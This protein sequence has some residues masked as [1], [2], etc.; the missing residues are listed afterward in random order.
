MPGKQKNGRISERPWSAREREI[1]TAGG[2]IIAAQLHLGVLGYEPG[3]ADG[4]LGKRTRAA[5]ELF[6]TNWPLPV[7]GDLE[8]RTS[9]ALKQAVGSLPADKPRNASSPPGGASGQTPEQIAGGDWLNTESLRNLLKGNTAHMKFLFGGATSILY[10]SADGRVLAKNPD[11]RPFYVAKWKT[12]RNQWCM[13]TNGPTLCYKV[14]VKGDVI[15]GWHLEKNKPV[16]STNFYM[17]RGD[18][19]NLAYTW[20]ARMTE[21][22]KRKSDLIDVA[23]KAG[24][25]LFGAALYSV[26]T[27]ADSGASAGQSGASCMGGIGRL[28]DSGNCLPVPQRP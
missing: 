1:L 5:L 17:L 25:L 18:T 7:T 28:N 9:D 16:H 10:F 23:R 15:Q 22:A 20:Q 27:G 12:S 11:T 13:E 24:L 8:R 2:D 14:K 21:L 26:V 6:Q 3:K 4:V 19:S